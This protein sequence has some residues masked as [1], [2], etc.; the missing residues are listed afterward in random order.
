[1]LKNNSLNK[2][3]IATLAIELDSNESV[4]IDTYDSKLLIDNQELKSLYSTGDVSFFF[5]SLETS[6]EKIV[7]ILNPLTKENHENMISGRHSDC[8]SYSEVIKDENGFTTKIIYYSDLLK[9]DKVKEE[10]IN[11]DA[12]KRV[13]SIITNI[14]TNNI[15]ISTEIQNI[16]RVNNV[17]ENI[18]ITRG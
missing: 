6:Y 7:S 15:L 3:I 17:I 12:N 5:D 10:I 13:L 18:S 16:A 4:V 14:Y 1:M 2:I 8:I 11:R 9:N